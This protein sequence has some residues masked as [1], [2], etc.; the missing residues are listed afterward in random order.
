MSTGSDLMGLGMPPMLANIV[1]ETGTG[2]TTLT[3][4]GTSFATS[5]KINSSQSAVV[6]STGVAGA[7]AGIGLPPV[8]TAT[9]ILL[10]DEVLIVNS[11]TDSLP[12]YAST[13]VIIFGYYLADVVHRLG[14]RSV[15]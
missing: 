11:G 14:R 10:G 12:V 7:N 5:T 1:S 4:A 13:G 15:I 8:G 2:P 3:A 9:G 6:C